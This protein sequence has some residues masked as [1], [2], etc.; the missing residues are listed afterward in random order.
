[1][2]KYSDQIC[3]ANQN[4]YFTFRKLCCLLDNVGKHGRS[5]QYG[6]CQI[7]KAIDTHSEYLIL[8]TS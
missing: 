8:I 5:R 4:T 2:T 7:S 1:M 3:T 6:A